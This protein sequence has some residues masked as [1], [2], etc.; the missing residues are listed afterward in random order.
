MKKKE[1]VKKHS[2]FEYIR[3]IFQMVPSLWW[4]IIGYTVFG[5]IG[6]LIPVGLVSL[7]LEYYKIGMEFV[8]IVLICLAVMVGQMVTEIG[9]YLLNRLTNYQYRKLRYKMLGKIFTKLEDIDYETYQSPD[10]LN[11]Y[12][13]LVSN[14][15]S[16][17]WQTFWALEELI[18]G[19]SVCV[20]IATILSMIHP[21]I[22]VYALG[23]GV[24]YYF[25]YKGIA[26]LRHK[27]SEVIQPQI[28][29]RAYIRRMFYLKEPAIDV[30]TSPIDRL[31][32]NLNDTIGDKVI[33]EVDKYNVPVFLLS[34]VANSL[35]KSIYGFAVGFIAYATIQN[36]AFESFVALI[37]AA[38]TLSNNIWSLSE[39]FASLQENLIYKKD[40]FKIMDIN[41]KLEQSGESKVSEMERI[42]LEHVSFRY[43][44]SDKD[45]LHDMN[46]EI[47]KGMKIAVVGENGAGKTTFVKLL[48]RLYDPSEG[49]IYLN[50]EEYQHF[51]P[52]SIRKRISAVFQNFQVYALT[53]AE[54]VLLKK[55]TT[56]E[57]VEKVVE[58]LQFCGLYEKI[59]KLPKGIYTNVTKEFDKEGL[60]LSGGERQK[61]AIARAFASDAEFLILDE[62]SSALDPI[63]ESKLY[64]QMITMSEN[65]TILFISHRLSTTAIADQIYLF[66]NG[67]IVEAGPHEDLMQITNGKYKTMFEVQAKEYQKAG[68]KDENIAK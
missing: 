50:G 46:L 24:I 26:K 58:A 51:Y 66:E 33:R 49:K 44:E 9:Y 12:T 40:Y 59:S 31:L 61:L 60:E 53:V 63:A 21:L 18:E 25:L 67:E 29:E 47:K 43:K 19:F 52:Q 4:S 68:A 65:K 36:L 16:N 56:Q 55:V 20:A 15:T 5:I 42:T 2:N 28:R 10:F 37:A 3:N 39:G 64:E 8:Y 30:R 34:A 23:V 22:I 48:L 7:L 62:P 38:S 6:S 57:E 35:M 32:L 17:A 45:A 54:N 27:S 1:K 14:G 41:S 11:H 13:K